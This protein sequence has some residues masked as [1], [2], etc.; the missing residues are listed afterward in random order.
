ME[1]F[2]PFFKDRNWTAGGPPAM[3]VKRKERAGTS[4]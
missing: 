4:M 1:L 3:G 2:E